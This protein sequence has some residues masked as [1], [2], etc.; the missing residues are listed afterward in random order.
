MDLKMLGKLAKQKAEGPKAP[1]AGTAT[2][3]EIAKAVGLEERR[4][5]RLLAAGKVVR[6]GVLA[7]GV[8]GPRCS[9]YDLG[10]V[11]VALG[12]APAPKGQE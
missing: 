6:A 5:S 9:Y 7:G 3:A 12:L 1:P 8:H 11:A 4:V 2:V 10:Q